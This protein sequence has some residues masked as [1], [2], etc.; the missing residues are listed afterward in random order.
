MGL[1]VERRWVVPGEVDLSAPPLDG[2][3]AS[4]IEQVYLAPGAVPGPGGQARLRR[5]RHAD[6]SESRT[7]TVKRGRGAVRVEDEEEVDVVRYEHLLRVAD[8][9][10]RPLRKTR[11][12]FVWQD[13]VWELDELREPVLARLLECELPDEAGLGTALVLPPPCATAVEVTDDDAW[14]NGSLAQGVLP[15]LPPSG[16]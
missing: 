8:P 13:R 16:M 3:Q 7:L 5:R 15:S 10:R 6:G 2:A 14:T 9:R 12:R 1:E 4:E 11:Y